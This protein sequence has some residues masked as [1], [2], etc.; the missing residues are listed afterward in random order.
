AIA[1]VAAVSFM[2]T[3]GNAPAAQA[4]TATIEER[5][6]ADPATGALDETAVTAWQRAATAQG[7]DPAAYNAIY[8]QDSRTYSV[9][10][11][12][13]ITAAP[14]YEITLERGSYRVLEFTAAAD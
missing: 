13:K 5:P 8:M 1:T 10:L 3:R 14:L 11:L 12:D 4:I 9:T 6:A 7:L 2:V